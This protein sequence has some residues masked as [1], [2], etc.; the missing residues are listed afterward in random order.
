MPAAGEPLFTDEDTAWALALQ[1][2]D[3]DTCPLCNLPLSVCADPA[4]E[5]AYKG[6]P[7]RT[8]WPTWAIAQ[9]QVNAQSG[10][11]AWQASTVWGARHRDGFTPPPPTT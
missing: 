11:R 4:Y 9:A 5:M 8:C 7:I 10:D 6:E 1:A 2:E 3:D